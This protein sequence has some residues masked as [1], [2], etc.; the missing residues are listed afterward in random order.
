M[1]TQLSFQ[2]D[3]VTDIS[4]V[5]VLAGLKG[6]N[7]CGSNPGNGKLADLTPLQGLRLTTLFCDFTEV[8]YLSP[9][10]GMPL[11]RLEC[12]YSK[13]SDLT[14]LAGMPLATLWCVA[15]RRC[16]ISRRCAG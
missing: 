9:L 13:V 7:C 14:P 10:K 4:P 2:S 3:N 11:T 1:V 8:A 16:P 12:G 6:L 15:P 5:R